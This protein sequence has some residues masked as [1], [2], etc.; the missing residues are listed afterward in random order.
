MFGGIFGSFGAATQRLSTTVAVRSILGGP[1]TQAV[2]SM[3]KI[4]THKGAA[5]RWKALANG[6]FSRRQ[7]GLRHLNRKLSPSARRGK[8][9]PVLCTKGQKRH[10]DKLLPY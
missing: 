9:A 3:S 2:R 10:L 6:L 1:Q 8:H 7:A 4:K 5:K